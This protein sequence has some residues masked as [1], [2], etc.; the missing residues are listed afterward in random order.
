MDVALAK[1]QKGGGGMEGTKTRSLGWNR[2]PT[3]GILSSTMWSLVV[4]RLLRYLSEVGF[5][6]RAYADDVSIIII[7]DDQEIAADSMRSSLFI[8]KKWCREVQLTVN[9]EKAEAVLFTRKHKT[10]PVTG[11]KLLD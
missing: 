1:Q 11:L 2:L 6:I 5:F 7:A 8:V 10:R 3:G 4:Y 9:P